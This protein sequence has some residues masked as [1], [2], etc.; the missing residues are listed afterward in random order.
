[1]VAVAARP[2]LLCVIT[3]AEVGGAQ[4]YVRNL[5]AAARDEFDVTV[6]AH[7]DGPLRSAAAELGVPFV[8]LEHVRRELSPVHDPLG[9]LELFR[10]FRRL[11]PDVVHLN[12][13]KAG[14]LGRTAAFLGRVPVRVFTAHG[15]A[16]TTKVDLATRLYLS[17]DRMAK[18]FAT[19]IVCVSEADRLAGIAAR[20]CQAARTVVIPN[21]VE[22][23]AEPERRPRGAGPLRIISV[24]RLAE[25]KDFSTLVQA[26]ALLEP[27]AARLQILGN[28]PLREGLE[29]EVAELGLTGSV[30]LL[31]EVPDVRPYLAESDVFVLSSLSEG[32][33]LSALEAMAAGLPVVASA[34]GGLNEIV[35]EGETGLLVAP[36]RADELAAALARVD[37]DEELRQRLGR[38]GRERAEARYSL[39][40]WSADHLELYRR[41]LAQAHHN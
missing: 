31:G 33:P 13:S 19:M 41:L 20:T 21:A 25:P 32:M 10:L 35:V 26:L 34:V 38:A 29:A 40:R 24:G 7:G 37:A 1:M 16:F 17:S 22:L 30:E 15:W 9:L 4:T 6:A 39:S 3:L 18:S 28:G 5:I 36:A 11:R 12:S 23:G 14:I 2:R 8:P 27:G